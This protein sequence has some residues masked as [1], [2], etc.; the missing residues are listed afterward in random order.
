MIKGKFNLKKITGIFFVCQIIFSFVILSVPTSSALAAD[1]PTEPIQFTP[2]V[3]IPNSSFTQNTATTVDGSLLARYILTYYNYGLA[4]VGILATI[5]LMGAGVLWLTSGGDS[6][7]VSQA[8]DLISGS[9]TGIAI[10]VCAWIILN[11]INPNLTQLASIS[12]VAIGKVDVTYLTCCDPTSGETKTPAKIVD[13]K[14]IS[15]N[16]TLTGQEIKCGN[17]AQECGA[18]KFCNQLGPQKFQCDTVQNST[19]S[20]GAKTGYRCCEYAPESSND[21]LETTRV[22]RTIPIDGK[23]NCP[24]PPEELTYK[25]KYVASYANYSC[26]NVEITASSCN[27]DCAGK[28]DG[29]NCSNTKNGYCYNNSC[30]LNDGELNEPCGT[31]VGAKCTSGTISCSGSTQHSSGG[32]NCNSLRLR[33]CY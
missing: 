2:Q 23:T 22:C 29:E 16:G 26:G 24:A 21:T 9:I 30:W 32:R 6:G 8:K 3:S 5:I 11:T 19:A 33:C 28:K 4:V 7:K 10:L 25:T 27:L 18:N 13:G 12:P 1:T 31:N 14:Y 20:A 17:N 15:I